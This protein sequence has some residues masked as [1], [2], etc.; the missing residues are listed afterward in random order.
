MSRCALFGHNW[1]RWH[2]V[3]STIQERQC[4]RCGLIERSR[5]S[6]YVHRDHYRVRPD[7]IPTDRP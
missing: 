2:L 1:T 4:K 6:I 5:L 3:D 7:P